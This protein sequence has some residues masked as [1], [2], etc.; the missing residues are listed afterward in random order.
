MEEESP[1]R[2]L[3]TLLDINL[4]DLSRILRDTLN[5]NLHLYLRI[6]YCRAALETMNEMKA[7]LKDYEKILSHRYHEIISSY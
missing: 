2:E 4:S 7:H 6:S 5:S 3:H 1:I